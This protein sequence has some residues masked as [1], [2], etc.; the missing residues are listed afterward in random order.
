MSAMLVIPWVMTA[1]F[2]VSA[3]PAPNPNSKTTHSLKMLFG[4]IKVIICELDCIF[5]QIF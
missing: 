3:E 5:S 1:S 4:V 2:S